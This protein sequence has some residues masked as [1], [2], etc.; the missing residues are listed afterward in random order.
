MRAIDREDLKFFP[1]KPTHPTGNVRCRAIPGSGVRITIGCQSRL[2]FRKIFQPS[3]HYPRLRRHIAAEAGEDIPDHGNSQQSCGDHIERGADA[4]QETTAG[5]ST[6]RRRRWAH[7]ILG[8]TVPTPSSLWVATP[9][10]LS[11]YV[12]PA[13]ECWNPSRHGCLRTHPA[14]LDAGHP[15]R[16]DDLHFHFLWASVTL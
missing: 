3:E 5:D 6:G 14:K 16:P 4:K 10:Q 13:C 7:P 1:R 15:C 8:H 2:I 9:A 11:D 12:I